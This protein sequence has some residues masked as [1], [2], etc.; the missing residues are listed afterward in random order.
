MVIPVHSIFQCLHSQTSLKRKRR[1]QMFSIDSPHLLIFGDL[2]C[3]FL[4]Y[5]SEL[6]RGPS[7][8]LLKR[9]GGGLSLTAL[10]IDK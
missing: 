10:D 6:R 4:A 2:I 8:F 5:S 9:E 1:R 3:E 7:I